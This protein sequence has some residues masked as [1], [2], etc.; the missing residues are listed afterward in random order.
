MSELNEFV[1]SVQRHGGKLKVLEYASAIGP[2]RL[3]IYVLESLDSHESTRLAR[4]LRASAILL[5]CLVIQI[6]MKREK[7]SNEERIARILNGTSS[8]VVFRQDIVIVLRSDLESQI[9]LL[10]YFGYSDQSIELV[11]RMKDAKNLLARIAAIAKFGLGMIAEGHMGLFFYEKL[12]PQP[13]KTL[14]S[15]ISQFVKC[16]NIV[17][18]SDSGLDAHISSTGSV[19]I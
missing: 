10:E 14:V 12:R 15:M 2:A 16:H 3:P 5:D 7:I 13:R 19:V 18:L 4:E 17:D 8:E 11:K 1:S 9:F 6:P